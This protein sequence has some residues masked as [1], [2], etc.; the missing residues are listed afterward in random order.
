MIS[1]LSLSCVK[2]TERRYSGPQVIINPTEHPGATGKTG[3]VM[4]EDSSPPSSPHL[5]EH[6]WLSDPYAIILYTHY[7]RGE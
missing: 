1:V 5:V 3:M 4:E 7:D 2:N 6:L